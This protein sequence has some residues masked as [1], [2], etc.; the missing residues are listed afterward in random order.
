MKSKNQ[1][2]KCVFMLLLIACSFTNI[3]AQGPYPQT[4][5]HSICLN[6]TEPYGVVLTTGATYKWNIL[7]ITGGNGIIT[8]G[9]TPNLISVNWTATGTATL[10]VTETIT[11]TG[12]FNTVSIPVTVNA[13][14]AAPTAS[15]QTVCSDGT[16]TQTLTATATGGTIT[17]YT[18]A[19]GGTVVS[20]PTQVGVGTSTYYAQS[21]NG[22]CTSTARTKVVLTI[23]AALA[24]PTASDQTVCSDGTTT[25][26]LTAT[27]T[28]GTITW[29]SAATG[30]TVVTNPTQV[31]VGTS[32]YFAQA[33][34]G[35]CTSATRT[36]VKLTIT[37]K[38]ATTP[39]THN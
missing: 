9:A 38:P 14:P 3:F 21:S 32:T 25:Q 7:T 6:A 24:A 8:P 29:Y 37:P 4:G 16:T 12:C 34:N 31:G 26:T 13:L 19:T 30:G 10:Q 2:I 1:I 28:G 17:W 11:A 35:S 33:S 22:T 20:N 18:A 36:Q 27:A 23:T 39:I 15:D 5:P